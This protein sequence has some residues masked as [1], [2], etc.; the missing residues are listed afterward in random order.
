MKNIYFVLALLFSVS[1]STFAQTS[2][3]ISSGSYY[4]TPSN[5]SI[6]VGDTVVWLN[7]SGNHNVNFI[8]SAVTGMN[9]NNPES[10]I[11]TP[12]T[13]P[14]LYTHIFTIPGNYVYDCSVGAHAANGM[15]GSL[16]VNGPPPANSVYDI[17]SNSVDHTTLKVAVDACS[18]NTTLSGPGP[19]TLFAPTDAAFNALPSGTLA[20]LL[21]DIPLLTS[22]LT[23]HVVGDSIVSNTLANGQIG[24]TLLGTNFTVTINPSG[25]YIDN[26][27]VTLADIPANNGVVHVIDAVLL[28]NP[29]CTDP[30]ATNYDV[31]AIVDD[32][33]CTYAT[34]SVYDVVVTSTNHTL[35]E[36]AIDTCG[37]SATLSGPG[38]F[39]LFAP[40]DAAF[41]ALGS[42]TIVSL[43]NNVS[44]LTDI[45]KHHVIGDSLISGTL[46]NGQIL[47]TLLGTDLTVSV[48]PNGILIDN[49]LV[50]FP[51]ITADNGVVHVIDAVLIP[52]PGCTD[53]NAINFDPNAIFDDG[54]CQYATNS[55]YDVIVTSADHG[56][57][58]VGID[59]C[60]L[61]GYLSG[62]GPFTVFAPTDAA[63]N[64]LGPITLLALLN[65]IPTLT[66]ILKHHVVGD[67][68]MSGML[69][70]GL[71]LTT[72]F[73]TDVTVT[74]GAS[75]IL[76][77]NALVTVADFQADNGVVHVI[78]AVLQPPT[79]PTNSVYDII[80]GSNDHTILTL[81][82]DTC[83]LVGTLK[84]PGP[85]TVFAP[86]DNAFSNLPL[87]TLTALLNDL[88]QLTD[89]LKH[90]VILDSVTSG[91][92]SNAQTVTTLLGDDITVTIN[93]SGVY[94]DNAMVT[95][96][97]IVADNGVVHVI[98]AVLLPSS[99]GIS[100]MSDFNVSE[101]KYSI[102]LL[103]EKVNRSKRNQV[104][105]DI[106]S[107]GK[108]VKRFNP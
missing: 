71:L 95:I 1:A 91:M 82:V 37:L 12:T 77:D 87:G 16:T 11:S 72:L 13:G 54:S 41:N 49:A 64:A 93:P 42:G 105:L 83:G 20:A 39:T 22:I 51:D 9:Y 65:D 80:S 7:N 38:P 40:T 24:T 97:D 33:S 15:V 66:N 108:V 63:F 81:A 35:L 18:L 19:F 5:L 90:H 101:Y 4:Y 8:A 98:D 68:L 17:V 14:I 78:D 79:N 57:L 27:L 88:P 107:N 100:N 55:V 75:G 43:L 53:P 2:H 60:G 25:I 89:I 26:A 67:S 73:G 62:P 59:T 94:I 6:N 56:V 69:S 30:T 86:T 106:Y 32:G 74:V 23:H 58:E 96:A 76:I 102:N 46:V 61:D 31:N 28:P 70:N 21:A 103:G 52:N 99:T 45:L 50:T 3:T 104:V 85:F 44:L 34:N 36:I 92:L 84:G 47:P 48:S 10:F 29:G